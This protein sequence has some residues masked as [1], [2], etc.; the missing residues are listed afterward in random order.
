MTVSTS[1]TLH[2]II[3]MFLIVLE[4]QRVTG[5]TGLKHQNACKDRT[6]LLFPASIRH[7]C[8]SRHSPL[9]QLAAQHPSLSSVPIH[10]HPC[11]HVDLTHTAPDHGSSVESTTCGC[12]V[13]NPQEGPYSRGVS[14]DAENLRFHDCIAHTYLSHLILHSWRA[15]TENDSCLEFQS[16]VSFCCG[17][18][19]VLPRSTLFISPKYA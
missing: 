7:L 13:P 18:D 1:V 4:N 11:G 5:L 3:N 15:G 19:F 10:H 6:P 12:K 2:N 16:F 14:E 9:L 8:S 17:F